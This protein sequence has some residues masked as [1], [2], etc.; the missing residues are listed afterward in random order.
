[1]LLRLKRIIEAQKIALLDWDRWN[2]FLVVLFSIGFLYGKQYGLS[3]L[4]IVWMGVL[5]GSF[6]GLVLLLI[7]KWYKK[8]YDIDE[9]DFKEFIHNKTLFIKEEDW[10]SWIYSAD[11][12]DDKEFILEQIKSNPF[13]Y[14]YASKNL[15]SDREV[16][17]AAVSQAGYLINFVPY[18]LKYDSELASIALV[19]L[20]SA[21]FRICSIQKNKK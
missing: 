6:S 8:E 7:S 19:E 18:A 17:L 4:E 15:K 12:I 9:I 16:A 1:M 13:A 20:S 14:Y 21:L 5:V 10:K 2:V 3:W 11:L